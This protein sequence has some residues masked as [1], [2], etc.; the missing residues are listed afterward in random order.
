MLHRSVLLGGFAVLVVLTVASCSGDGPT[1]APATLLASNQSVGGITQSAVP[2]AAGSQRIEI[3]GVTVAVEARTTIRVGGASAATPV[4]ISVGAV[5]P[6]SRPNGLPASET[7]AAPLVTFGPSGAR[8]SP[9]LAVTIDLDSDVVDPSAWLCDDL[10]AS[11][12]RRPATVVVDDSVSPPQRKLTVAVD[13]FSLLAITT[14]PGCEYVRLTAKHSGKCTG[15]SEGRTDDGAPLIQWDCLDRS[16]PSYASTYDL[17]G[18]EQHFMFLPLTGGAF[19]IQARHSGKCLTA[20]GHPGNVVQM[21]C[22][23]ASSD[24]RFTT[25]PL[26]DGHYQISTTN[27]SG[28]ALDVSGASTGNG[29]NIVAYPAN[30]ANNQRFRSLAV[31]NPLMQAQCGGHQGTIN[32]ITG[33]WFGTCLMSCPDDNTAQENDCFPE[34]QTAT[35]RDF[36]S[37]TCS[38]YDDTAWFYGFRLG[39]CWGKGQQTYYDATDRCAFWHDNLCFDDGVTGDKNTPRGGRCFGLVEPASTQEARAKAH[40][41]YWFAWNS[42]D[43][44]A[45]PRMTQNSRC[46][47]SGR[48][49]GRDVNIRPYDA[50]MNVNWAGQ[51]GGY[52]DAQRWMSGD[53]NGDGWTDLAKV[54][55]DGGNASIDVH[56]ATPWGFT[57]QRWATRWGAIADSDKW[58]AGDFDG[59][60]KADIVRVSD[61]GGVATI[62]VFRSTGTGFQ[63][64]IVFCPDCTQGPCPCVMAPARWATQQG[65][66]WSTQKWLAGDFSGDGKA[67]LA[68]VFNEGGLASFDVFVSTGSSFAS[69]CGEGG[70]QA[71]S[72]WA[73]QQ[74]GYWD[75]QKWLS[76][77]F[78]GTSKAEL[79]RVFN[80]GGQASVDVF[81]SLGCTSTT[82]SRW[83]TQ[84]GEFSNAQGWVAEDFDDDGTTDLARAFYD[85]GYDSIGVNRSSGGSTFLSVDL[86]ALRYGLHL[87]APPLPRAV[88]EAQKWLGGKFNGVGNI[89]KV[90]DHG[91]GS[92]STANGMATI[93]V[94]VR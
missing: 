73:T 41:Q 37:G 72:H 90:Y 74:G 14:C 69:S 78:T 51:Q 52:W 55:N 87:G 23:A 10:G 25:T 43:G 44:Y 26:D 70:S 13:H 22:N 54:F 31:R 15:I 83:I 77:H 34:L 24:Q 64:N 92:G 8:F 60:G 7:L 32:N 80:D 35:W 18:R 36:F 94:Y 38:I 91:L 46:R 16:P 20:S 71:Y 33:V 19:Q 89:A 67:D 59:D 61:E 82:F 81:T 39:W 48:P 88:R 3:P 50:F 2:N 4:P 17:T 76:G 45:D 75:E 66:F 93:D 40:G 56:L 86:W 12:E 85:N 65:G 79:A 57:M 21:P 9:P 58:L 28:Y 27:S 29:A 30:G 47:S 49:F 5:V 53:F 6:T 1:R 11:C 42:G 84:D 63:G 68:R 62:D